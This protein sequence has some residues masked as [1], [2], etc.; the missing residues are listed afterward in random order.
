MVL[1]YVY[2]N[3]C[4]TTTLGKSLVWD[5]KICK[6]EWSLGITV[7]RYNIWPPLTIQWVLRFDIFQFHILIYFNFYGGGLLHRS[8]VVVCSGLPAD[9]L[10]A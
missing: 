10:C 2:E 9:F 1:L 5:N 6:E 8:T 7:V 4:G 3:E